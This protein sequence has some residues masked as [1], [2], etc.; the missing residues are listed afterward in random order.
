[1]T[2][3]LVADADLDTDD[4]GLTNV[5]EVDTYGTDYDNNDTDGDGYSDGDEV[6]NSTDPLDPL[7]HPTPVETS[8]GWFSTAMGIG[9]LALI[10]ITIAVIVKFNKKRK[11]N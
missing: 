3:P 5:E 9:D 7:D 4:D 10:A 2:D 8:P 6:G 1:F 11:H